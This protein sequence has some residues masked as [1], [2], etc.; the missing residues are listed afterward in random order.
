MKRPMFIFVLGLTAALEAVVNAASVTAASATPVAVTTYHYDNL[1]TGWNSNETILTAASFPS[2][3]GVLAT[4]LVDG[5]ITAQPLVV[6]G[7]QVASGRL[8]TDD[9]VYVVTQNNSVYAIDAST[10]VILLRVNLGAT[11]AQPGRTPWGIMSTPVIDPTNQ[12]LFVIDYYNSTPS[13]PTPTPAYQLHAL[14]LSTLKDQAGSPVTITA[15]QT[16]T[17]GSTYSFNAAVTRQRPALLLQN[18][19]VY[20][21][22]G[23]DADLDANLSR[24]WLLGWNETTLALFGNQL[25]DSETASADAPVDPPFYLSSIWM[26]GYGVAGDGTDLYF[27]TG[28]SD[29]NWTVVPEPCPPATTWNG[30][31]QIQESVVRVSGNLTPLRGVFTPNIA[32]A[33]LALDKSDLDLSSGGV[34]VLPP[35][36]GNYLAVAGVKDGRLF[37]FNRPTTGGLTKISTNYS[38]ARCWCGPSYFVGSDGI[39]RVVTS[40]GNTLHTFHVNVTV[41]P[42]K[43]SLVGASATVGLGGTQDP[44]FFTSVSSNGTTP[45]SAIIWAV[46]RPDGSDPNNPTAVSLYA[47]SATSSC[48]GTTCTYARLYSAEAGAWPNVLNNANIVPVVANGNVYVASGYL[49][50]ANGLVG[51]LNIFGIP[52]TAPAATV[53]ATLANTAKPLA[54]PVAP[55]NSPHHI[56]GTLVAVDGSML[57]LQTRDHKS[58]TVD[59]SQAMKHGQLGAPLIVGTPLTAEGSTI[60]GNGALLADLIVRAM[61]GHAGALWPQDK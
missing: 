7:S 8:T 34:L 53:N 46:S 59:A 18:G 6:P 31:T 42:P 21:G 55:L 30:V 58:R 60:E 54:S 51:Q 57:T 37:F 24:G 19:N 2:N 56:T 36:N 27:A 5:E 20:A 52:P 29:C 40:H 12:T 35:L 28:N 44:G 1:R 13:G 61:E 4:V 23:S 41:S 47:F 43:L 10:G 26:S 16:L 9:I 50:A 14:S 25:N 39:A 33:T 22:F 48:S 15:S 3:F 38:L 32:P 17:D 45:G 49:N 11:A